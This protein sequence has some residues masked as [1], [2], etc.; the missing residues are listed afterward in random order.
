[1]NKYAVAVRLVLSDRDLLEQLAE[2]AA[3]LSQAALKMIR[4]YK[5]SDNVT[6]I[7][8]DEAMKNLREEMSDV[9][10]VYWLLS[11]DERYSFVEENPKFE[12][13]AKRLGVKRIMA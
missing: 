1:M 13:W 8:R 3:E 4:A 2:E 7:S 5:L 11:D 10:S 12:R 9:V 6:P